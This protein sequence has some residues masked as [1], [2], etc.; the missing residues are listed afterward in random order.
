MIQNLNVTI[1]IGSFSSQK[2]TSVFVLTAIWRKSVDWMFQN[3]NSNLIIIWKYWNLE[4]ACPQI[5]RWMI[6][7]Y[8]CPLALISRIRVAQPLPLQLGVLGL[9][10]GHPHSLQ[11]SPPLHTASTTDQNSIINIVS[12][13][14][15]S[16]YGILKEAKSVD[17]LPE[18]RESSSD[19]KPALRRRL[20]AFLKLLNMK[21]Y[22]IW[23][24]SKFRES[25][26]SNV[27]VKRTVSLLPPK[28]GA[29]LPL[30]GEG[31]PNPY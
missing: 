23:N 20:Y 19:H 7:A 9:A 4:E 27:P 21:I 8:Q 10:L 13:W 30:R 11:P 2:G 26:S 16:W 28:L 22:I 3:S 14:K 25:E 24:I 12:I 29:D 5:D 1:S 6:S 17:P 15:F 18:R 31:L